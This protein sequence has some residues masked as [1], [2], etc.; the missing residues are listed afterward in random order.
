M[1]STL[2]AL[3]WSETVAVLGY[4]GDSRAYLLRR[5]GTGA[6]GM[7]QITEDH[8]YEHLVADA[9]DVPNLPERLSR[10]L[11]GR[12]DGRSPDITRWNLLLGDRFMLCSDGLSS[13]VPHDLIDATLSASENPQVVAD[14]LV[15]LALDHGGPDN[16]TVIVADV[17]KRSR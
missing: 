10:W 17:S 7:R 13:Y 5:D 1:G 14:R 6:E 8:T 11:D 2:V 3:M 9:T 4:V 15:S 12:A 16:V